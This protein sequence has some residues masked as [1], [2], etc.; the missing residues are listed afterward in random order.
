MVSVLLSDAHYC[1]LSLPLPLP[2]I[3]SPP[4]SQNFL[5]S[6]FESQFGRMMTLGNGST[7][8]LGE[9]T[10]ELNLGFT[11]VFIVELLINLLGYWPQAFIRNAWVSLALSSSAPRPYPAPSPASADITGRSGSLTLTVAL[12]SLPPNKRSGQSPILQRVVSPR[13][14]PP[15]SF[16]R[17]RTGASPLSNPSAIA[18]TAVERSALLSQGSIGLDLVAPRPVA[19]LARRLRGRHVH[20]RARLQRRPLL[21]REAH[22]AP[23]RSRRRAAEIAP[24]RRREPRRRRP[25]PRPRG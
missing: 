16:P 17:R 2:G 13:T 25:R 24:P 1:G 11:I 22:A 7:T 10:D 9:M 20:H 14:L 6:I 4:L 12:L 5:V 3:S 23:Q 19:E 8:R 18:S 21:A 15:S